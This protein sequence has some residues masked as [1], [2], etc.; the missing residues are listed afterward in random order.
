MSVQQNGYTTSQLNN[1]DQLD[2]NIK[3]MLILQRRAHIK[4]VNADER[5]I[6]QLELLRS[7]ID[8]DDATQL[9]LIVILDSL[10]SNLKEHR[11]A[12]FE[13][14]RDIERRCDLK[15]RFEGKWNITDEGNG[16]VDMEIVKQLVE[17]MN[18]G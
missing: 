5:L 14:I 13:L 4:S 6:V 3:Q 12:L 8:R 18:T 1:K 16:S 10:I 15:K 7:S 17:K 11:R 2:E 9:S